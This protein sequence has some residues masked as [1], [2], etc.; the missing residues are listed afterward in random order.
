MLNPF[1][2]IVS[3]LAYRSADAVTADGE[4]WDIYVSN[5]EL[6]DKSDKQQRPRISD[7]R[8][9]SWSEQPG[10]KRGPIF[11]PGTTASG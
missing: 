5:E 8:Y 1:R 11:A 2:G 3:T 6:L 4:H 10:L 7:I 9:G